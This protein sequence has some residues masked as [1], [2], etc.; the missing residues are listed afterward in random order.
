[1]SIQKI[2]IF[3]ESIWDLYENGDRHLG[4]SGLNVAWHLQAL[5]IE[6]SLISRV[7]ND[8]NGIDILEA[9]R[10]WGIDPRHIQLDPDHPTA[11]LHVVVDEEGGH[12]FPSPPE[13]A[14]DFIT[15][16]QEWL[17]FDASTLMY[18]G[19]YMLRGE[20]TKNTIAAAKKRGFPVF[21]DMNLR[22]DYW[23]HALLEHWIRDI[24]YLKLSHH[25]LSLWQPNVYLT[26]DDQIPFLQ[27]MMKNRNIGTILLTLAE[28]GS[29]LIE[30]DTH[31][32]Q[33]PMT[34]VNVHNSVG[35]GDAY[36]AGFMYGLMKGMDHK[37]CVKHATKLAERICTIASATSH[38]KSFYQNIFT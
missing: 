10:A 14:L 21:V 12:H 13:H 29:V 36:C 33:K 6:S 24:A 23:D 27:D 18:H 5:G 16:K 22:E 20:V 35:A 28:Q 17:D 37:E 19:T 30:K 8:Q 7:S 9:I 2:M 3:G 34:K 4:G 31:H 32:V 25:E 11:Y 26:L 1:M 15:F 38:G